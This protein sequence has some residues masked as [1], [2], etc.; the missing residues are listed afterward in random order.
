VSFR[1]RLTVL[2][3]LAVTAA[4][5]GASFLVYY[6]DRGQLVNQVDSEL[7]ASQKL[8]PL[9]RALRGPLPPFGLALSGHEGT[10]LAPA[11]APNRS[12]TARVVLP[13]SL[14]AVQVEVVVGANQKSWS[15]KLGFTTM[16]IGGVHSRAL[17]IAAP[18]GIVRLSTSLVGVDR[19]LAHLRW[20][21]ILISVG[22][23]GVAV[24]LGALVS[25]RAL[26]PLR[27]LT[28]TTE[29]IVATGD[30]SRRTEQR[31]RDE[32]S[33]LSR[34]LDELLTMLEASLRTQRQLVADASHEL[35]TPITT[36]RANVE[37]LAE[38]GS[39]DDGERAELLVDVR[40]ELESM[41]TL[42]GEL[43][44]LARGE[45]RELP[46]RTFRLDEVVRTAVERT[47]RRSPGVSF[48]TRLEPSVV[49]GVPERVERAVSNLL[50]NASKWSP[51]SETVDVSVHGGLVEVRDRGPG[52]AEEHRPLVFNRFYRS[53]AARGMPG[54]GLGLAI[55]KQI[56]DAHDGTVSIDSAPGGG[57]VVRLQLSPSS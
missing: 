49:T 18:V 33:R 16:S 44:E 40:E 5:V 15:K 17:T 3:A 23:V 1:L 42:V 26:A 14:T 32:I 10:T 34:R 38:P 28:A 45:E 30:L 2:T 39:L 8:P 47:A 22:G 36:V 48:R 21:L 41:T 54:A 53:P 27:R 24:L 20:L 4:V 6:A 46:S 52:I 13:R 25:G 43:V 56:A 12:A 55:V 7:K 35:R 19:N 29:D 31:G 37:L 51:P 50:D 57:A 11:S 9:S